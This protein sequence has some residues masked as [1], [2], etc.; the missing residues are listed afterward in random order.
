MR[1]CKNCCFYDQCGQRKT[2]EFYAPLDETEETR[3]ELNESRKERE[4]FNEE[5][6]IYVKDGDEGHEHVYHAD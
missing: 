5:W 4:A 6:D 1:S 3:E 2:C